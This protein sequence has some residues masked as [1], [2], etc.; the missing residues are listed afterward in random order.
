MSPRVEALN[1]ECRGAN[2]NGFGD[3]LLWRSCESHETTGSEGEEGVLFVPGVVP[4]QRV[5][6]AWPRCLRGRRSEGENVHTWSRLGFQS[7]RHKRAF[8]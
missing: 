3:V 8:V 7:S 4:S 6:L 2:H 5:R 1:N